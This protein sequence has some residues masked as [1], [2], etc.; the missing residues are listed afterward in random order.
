E[1]L[2]QLRVADDLEEGFALA[3][4]R[5]EPEHG[6]RPLVQEKNDVAPVDGD[7]ALDHP[8][9]DRG[10][11]RLLVAEIVDLLAQPGR[12]PV[13]RPA[14]RVRRSRRRPPA[15]AA[16]TSGREPWFST[17]GRSSTATSESPS[18]RPSAAITVMREPVGREPRDAKA[19]TSAGEAPRETSAR[20]SSCMS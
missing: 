3:A 16:R 8:V 10:R 7:D 6:S 13:K 1:R 14:E 11:L 17:R 15:G 4:R 18:T 19:R 2:V 5:V 20:A 9:E 12:E